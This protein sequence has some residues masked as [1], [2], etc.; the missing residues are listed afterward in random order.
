MQKKKAKNKWVRPVLIVLIRA[1][2]RSEWSLSACKGWT[3]PGMED[4]YA[5]CT[6]DEIGC[7]GC[8]GYVSS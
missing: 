4:G 8:Q 7:H 2:D 1:G 5:L 6:L 3:E